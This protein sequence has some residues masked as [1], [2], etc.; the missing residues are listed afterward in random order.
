MYF[1]HAEHNH[2]QIHVHVCALLR[3]WSVQCLRWQERLLEAS[4]CDRGR[5]QDDKL[6]PYQFGKLLSYQSFACVSVSDWKSVS[7]SFCFFAINLFTTISFDFEF[8]NF[9]RFLLD[10][11]CFVQIRISRFQNASE[12]QRKAMRCSESIKDMLMLN[13]VMNENYGWPR[14]AAICTVSTSS[15]RK[16]PQS[17]PQPRGGG[18]SAAPKNPLHKFRLGSIGCLQQG[19]VEDPEAS[20]PPAPTHTSVDRGNDKTPVSSSFLFNSNAARCTTRTT[21]SATQETVP[22]AHAET[23][24]LV[25]TSTLT[26]SAITFPVQ[27]ASA[28]ARSPKVVDRQTLDNHHTSDS[29]ATN[30]SA[31]PPAGQN[32]ADSVQRLLHGISARAT[33]CPRAA[34]RASPA[35][36]QKI[37]RIEKGP[38]GPMLTLQDASTLSLPLI[39]NQCSAEKA[40]L[41]DRPRIVSHPT[42]EASIAHMQAKPL[43]VILGETTSP[44]SDNILSRYAMLD[45]N[46]RASQTN[47]STQARPS[48][49]K[50][51]K[52]LASLLPAPG[53]STSAT[54][55]QAPKPPPAKRRKVVTTSWKPGQR[56]VFPPTGKK[57]VTSAPVA[58][59][60]SEPAKNPARPLD[61]SVAKAPPRSSSAQQSIPSKCQ[62]EQHQ[63]GVVKAALRPDGQLIFK[64]DTG[65]Q[66][67]VHLVRTSNPATTSAQ[68][69]SSSAGNVDRKAQASSAQTNVSPSYILIPTDAKNVTN[70]PTN[71]KFLVPA[72]MATVDSVKALKTVFI[73]NPAANS[74]PSLVMDAASA[75]N[76]QSHTTSLGEKENSNQV[77]KY[78]WCKIYRM[79]MLL[80]RSDAWKLVYRLM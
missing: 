69:V 44:A 5:S 11:K 64:L 54:P 53:G 21:S 38:C 40:D 2:R 37:M 27:V 31:A 66:K 52:P 56:V 12:L 26:C 59:P 4:I 51:I 32:V 48:S 70:F 41:P 19:P 13:T 79:P 18:S 63:P 49:V 14:Q 20:S 65:D 39:R 68:S 43:H 60:V 50:V 62:Q 9:R 28:A 67:A 47:P 77:R 24:T 29:T 36:P 23:I 15:K 35:S 80:F 25:D 58:V 72:K 75:A 71:T 30:N 61:E 45:E 1:S 33:A 7:V 46:F 6:H 17:K 10:Q 42:A 73:P 78:F 74:I 76:S 57:R 3:H 8:H 55:G 22:S 16:R 34:V